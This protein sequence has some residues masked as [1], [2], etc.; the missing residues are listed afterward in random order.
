MSVAVGTEAGEVVLG[1]AE[2]EAARTI[3]GLDVR[4]VVSVGAVVDATTV[5]VVRVGAP[6]AALGGWP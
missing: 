5:V 2:P 1:G 4:A 3:L 6:R